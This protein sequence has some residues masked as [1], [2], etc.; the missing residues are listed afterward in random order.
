MQL[1]QQGV[2]AFC[3]QKLAARDQ[4][5][6]PAL[7]PSSNVP[8]D[9]FSSHSS[10]SRVAFRFVARTG[11]TVVSAGGPAAADCGYLA[12]D[13][14]YSLDMAR[15]SPMGCR[16][17]PDDSGLCWRPPGTADSEEHPAA[18]RVRGLCRAGSL[19]MR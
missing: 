1:R 18:D 6:A 8:A 12:A 2:F 13:S 4:V 3:I 10:C 9:R 14:G 15:E 11:H 7:Y 5:G 17:W 19:A 16:D